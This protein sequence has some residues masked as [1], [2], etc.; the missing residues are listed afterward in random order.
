[1][2]FTVSFSRSLRES[3]MEYTTKAPIVS[4]ITSKHR[5]NPFV[6]GGNVSDSIFALCRLA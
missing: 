1:M 4:R 6:V 3:D 5:K 2:L